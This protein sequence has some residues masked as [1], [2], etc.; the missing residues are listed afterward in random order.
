MK[1]QLKHS[2]F[3]LTQKQVKTLIDC[4]DNFRDRLIFKMLAYTGIRREELINIFI[5]DIDFKNLLIRVVGKGNK[6]RFVPMTP[7][8]RTDILFYLDKRKKGYLFP[9][10][11]IKGAPLNPGRIN[12]MLRSTGEKA[13]IKNPNP[14]L[15]F[16]NP[17]IFRHTFAR[18][19]IDRG[20]DFPTLRD[21]MGH[22]SINVT[23]DYY[24]STPLK[25]IQKKYS[26]IMAFA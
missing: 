7:D 23:L 16:I 1:K 3:V 21:I 10:K 11:K 9:A 20:M 5:S 15:K 18:L 22:S 26:E 4:P 12:S 2:Q 6:E 8:I 25:T 24:A 13:E 14:D 17:H 19:C